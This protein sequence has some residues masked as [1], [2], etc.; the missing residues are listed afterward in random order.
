MIPALLRLLALGV[1]LAAAG[2]P[3]RSAGAEATGSRPTLAQAL[4]QGGYVIFFRHGPAEEA[5]RAGAIAALPPDLRECDGANRSLT[6]AGVAQVRATGQALRALGIPVGSVIA[7]PSCRCVETAWYAFEQRPV[8]ERELARTFGGG[9][10]LR[11]LL[12]TRPGAGTNTVVVGHVSNVLAAADTS[13]E[14]GDALLVQPLDDGTFRV[15]ARV[16]PDGWAALDH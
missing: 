6:E 15:V 7:S 13:I 5:T 8:L 16:E 14:Q 3:A 2:L 10:A 12:G 11:R 1:L 9:R 4:R